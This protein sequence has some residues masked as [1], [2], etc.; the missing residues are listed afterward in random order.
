[1]ELRGL[2]GFL[3]SKIP[4]DCLKVDLNSVKKITIA[5]F[6]FLLPWTMLLNYLHTFVFNIF[7]VFDTLYLHN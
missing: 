5:L 7:L 1:M 2:G 4:L 3:G 6:Y